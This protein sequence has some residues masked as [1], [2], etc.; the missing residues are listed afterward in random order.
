MRIGNIIDLFKQP[1]TEIV[2]T[3]VLH[4]TG[5]RISE[6]Y[7]LVIGYDNKR[8]LIEK[9]VHEDE[10]ANCSVDLA[11]DLGN[12]KS[13][14]RYIVKADTLLFC[15][16]FEGQAENSDVI[17][18]ALE[19]QAT[20]L[21]QKHKIEK[22]N[23]LIH[24]LVRA[25]SS[26]TVL[27]SSAKNY[28]HTDLCSIWIHNNQTKHQVCIA[29]D[30]EELVGRHLSPDDANNKIY[31]FINSN[32][33]YECL[34][35]DKNAALSL[36]P[37]GI[38]S[39]TRFR[40]EFDSNTIGVFSFASRREG[41][42]V[43][44]ETGDVVKSL[45]ANA[46]HIEH[47]PVRESVLGF[48]SSLRKIPSDDIAALTREVCK[49]V[50]SLLDFEACS[51]FLVDDKRLNLA[52]SYD[53]EG[54]VQ[55]ANQGYSLREKS[56]TVSVLK[57]CKIRW[58]YAIE[59]ESL[60][61]N[62]YSEKCELPNTN[63]V[64]LPIQ[65]DE[66]VAIGVLRVKNKFRRLNGTKII[67]PLRDN[68]FSLLRSLVQAVGFR[69]SV[70]LSREALVRQVKTQ[71]MELADFLDHQRILLHE[72]RA[73]AHAFMNTPDDIRDLVTRSAATKVEKVSI[74]RE[75]DDLLIVAERL[76]FIL[77]CHRREHLF[78]KIEPQR[79][80]VLQDVVMPVVSTYE[81]YIKKQW[82]I[83]VIVDPSLLSSRF[84]IG[85]S[86]LLSVVMNILLDNAGKYSKSNKSIRI[87][88][89]LDRKN[90]I[91][92][93]L[94]QNDGYEILESESDKIFEDTFR[95]SN[96]R[97]LKIDGTGI[98]LNLAKEILERLGSKI[99]IASRKNPVTI[100]IEL[101]EDRT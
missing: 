59:A 39:M 41:Y 75:I 78:S 34:P 40:I 21:V 2:S 33:P 79:L 77:K 13:E 74:V 92:R 3:P 17:F 37:E 30:K 38:K 57:D 28:T 85:D 101:P 66:G 84:I 50:V 24:S 93:V 45:A 20:I 54:V 56:L 73:P 71:R 31:N 32:K 86:D 27:I 52:G 53:Y 25:Q 88:G 18:E 51:L 98:G 94:I 80:Y 87:Y 55:P 82:G 44:P 97:D 61:T 43:R 63:W 96:I 46:Y 1:R 60:S 62:G 26:L 5:Y 19:P 15:E 35:V 11:E 8:E 42:Y 14:V 29:S 83:D 65:N 6:K 23:Q 49:M 22:K 91:V 69:V 64:G 72:F 99:Y 100:A 4:G 68:D 7:F 36:A 76:D 9:I 58:S 12:D 47:R 89:E 95:G 81:T 48:S 67:A 90:D 16:S 70:Y 10:F